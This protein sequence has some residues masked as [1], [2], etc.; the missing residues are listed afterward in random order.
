MSGRADR[1]ARECESD[2]SLKEVHSFSPGRDRPFRPF[3]FIIG[4]LLLIS[5]T[6]FAESVP[7]AF[8]AANKLYEQGK[9]AEAA[10]TYEK[11]LKTG[12]ASEAICFNYGNALFKAGEIGRAIAAYQQAQKIA[13]R[14]PD[15]RANLQFARNQVQGPTVVPERLQRWLGK[16]SLD[17]WTCLAAA[18]VW[19]WLLLLTLLQ[20]RPALKSALKGYVPWT[21]AA[22]GILCA[23]FSAAFYFDRFAQ[24]AIIVSHEA[25]VRQAPLEESQSAFTLHDG[26]ELQVLDQKD[27]WLQ[28]QADAHRIGWVRRDSLVVTPSS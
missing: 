7:A 19:L 8:D 13:P 11:L 22:A 28:V 20:W 16:L 26:A 12:Q 9:Y 6:A 27:Q 17:E 15:V 1:I 2:A 4:V 23:C 10:A 3:F 18:T 14:D 24:R 21:G 25:T 5:A